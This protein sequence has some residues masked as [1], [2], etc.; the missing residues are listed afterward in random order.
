MSS[1]KTEAYLDALRGRDA[2]KRAITEEGPTPSRQAKLLEAEA[3]VKLAYAKLTGGEIGRLRLILRG[4]Y[5]G[6][7]A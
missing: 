7:P 6:E 2:I 3:R 4:A 1:R 5:P